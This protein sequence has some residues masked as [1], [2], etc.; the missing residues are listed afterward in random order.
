ME[1]NA[2]NDSITGSAGADTLYGGQDNDTVSGG[3]LNDLINGNNG[4][5]SVLGGAGSDS[6]FGNDGNDT[7][8]EAIAAATSEADTLFGGAGNDIF[9]LN[10]ATTGA[11][12]TIVI[13]DLASGDVINWTLEAGKFASEFT[14]SGSQITTAGSFTNADVINLSSLSTQLTATNLVITNGTT[15][16]RLLYNVSGAAATLTGSAAG[17]YVQ[18]GSNGDSVDAGAGVDKIYGGSGN[19][20][21][22][23]DVTNFATETVQAG[24]GT[25]NLTGVGNVTLTAAHLAGSVDLRWRGNLHAVDR[26]DQHHLRCG[27]C[28]YFG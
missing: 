10:T 23:F 13:G 21:I 1:G 20:A 4:N 8:S 27:L 15:A 7:I 26:R 24:L 28:G 12:D 3:A 16:S 14:L 11:I 9:N 5:D 2:G 25:D 18:A 17:D 19:D 6:V 22:A